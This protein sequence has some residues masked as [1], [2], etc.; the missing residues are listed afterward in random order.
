MRP[1]VLQI[2]A[3]FAR[4]PASGSALP[5]PRLQL[6]GRQGTNKTRDGR[7][8]TVDYTVL[9]TTFRAD[10]VKLPIDINHATEIKGPKGEEAEPIGWIVDLVVEDGRLFGLTQW[11]DKDRAARACRSYAYVSPAFFHDADG[12]VTR[13]KSAALVA[14]PA[15]ANQ[16]ALASAQT[17]RTKDTGGSASVL[18]AALGIG[19]AAGE[20]EIL[21]AIEALKARIVPR[22]VHEKAVVTLATVNA[23]LCRLQARMRAA[24]TERLISEAIASGKA[25]ASMADLYRSW[26]ASEE[27]LANLRSLL[28]TTPAGFYPARR[29]E[30]QEEALGEE[31]RQVALTLGLTEAEFLA[32]KRLH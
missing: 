26:C 32:A 23:E 11:T 28:A 13:L 18:C 24:E 16:P 22:E 31:E 8:F 29:S 10:G 12:R 2:A 21:T 27:G 7:A 9:V 3:L 19:A 17:A 6:F 1:P 15:L 25:P 14:S 5:P 20:A 4:V 30:R